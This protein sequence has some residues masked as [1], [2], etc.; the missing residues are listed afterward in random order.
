MPMH[1]QGNTPC[2]VLDLDMQNQCS[3]VIQHTE[4]Q[5]QGNTTLILECAKWLCM[6]RG[7]Q[8]RFGQRKPV[9]R[10]NSACWVQI[11]VQIWYRDLMSIF[12]SDH[13][14]P[15]WNNPL[16]AWLQ[17]SAKH[18]VS[19]IMSELAGT[20]NQWRDCLGF[21]A[22]LQVLWLWTNLAVSH[23][24]LELSATWPCLT[25]FCIWDSTLA[26]VTVWVV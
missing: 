24:L 18:N 23:A 10:G 19:N 4:E 25:G 9:H 7:V 5:E 14:S 22:Y 17:I 12:S 21:L 1:I 2:I 15:A 3:R 6:Y 11:R 8:L 16:S 13:W 26:M 20:H